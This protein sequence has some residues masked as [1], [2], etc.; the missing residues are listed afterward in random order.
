MFRFCCHIHSLA[1]LEAGSQ[2]SSGIKPAGCVL[3]G[4]V[5]FICRCRGEEVRVKFRFHERNERLFSGEAA[6]EV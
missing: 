5:G 2:C 3:T 6:V 1:E 4:V